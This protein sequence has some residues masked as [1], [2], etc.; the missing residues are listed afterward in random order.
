M[1]HPTDIQDFSHAAQEEVLKNILPFWMKYIDQEH[2]GFLGEVSS[3]GVADT[4]SPKGGILGARILWTFSEA[5]LRYPRPAFKEMAEHAYRFLNDHLWDDQYGGTYWLVDY[6]GQPLDTKKHIYA[7]AFSAYSLASYYMISH[8]Q[9]A[10]QKAIQIFDLMEQY[11]HDDVSGGY[12]EACERSWVLAGDFRLSDK[13]ADYNEK[14]SMNTHLHVLEAFTNLYRVWPEKRLS[15]RLKEMIDMFLEHI[16][17]PVTHH[18]ILFMDETWQPKSKVASFGHDIEGSWL[19]MEAAHVLGD[20]EVQARV[21]PISVQMAQAV[22]EEGLN[23]D[24]SLANELNPDGSRH[25]ALDWWPQAEN[26]VGMLNAYQLSGQEVFFH[27][28]QRGWLYIQK[29]MIDRQHG[30]WFCRVSVEGVPYD[31]PLVD[32]WKCPY[33]NSRA[34]FEIVERLDKIS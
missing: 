19:L 32:F 10:L 6:K 8:N 31:L 24:G 11:A 33:H 23:P 18:F 2:G 9:D 4:Q 30:E 3:Q 14:K 20:P 17:D 16:I 1:I 21:R 7:Q 25:D 34:C 15:V 22:C 28:A 5:H 27:A 13:E 29:S 12:F 26:V